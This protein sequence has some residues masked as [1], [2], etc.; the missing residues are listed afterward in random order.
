MLKLEKRPQSTNVSH[1][2]QPELESTHQLFVLVSSTEVDT[3]MLTRRVWE[4][5]NA[6]AFHVKFIG[7]CN[8]AGK[9]LATRRALVT[10][11]SMM[12]YGTLTSDIEVIV[13][14]NWIDSL[15]PRV[16][17]GDMVVYWDAEPAGLLRKPISQL[18]YA[19]LNVPL[20]IIP[21]GATPQ[22]ARSAWSSQIVAWIGFIA[23]VLGF[24]FLQTKIYQLAIGW[25]TVLALISVAVEFWLIWV[26]HNW[27][28]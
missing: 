22:D 26:W 6:G 13:G 25:A 21:G 12:N 20:Y 27:F 3:T 4:L 10:M 9:E 5:A 18:L 2:A 14:K 7:L 28:K 1:L 8:D 19:D 24:F 16:D 23:I 11:S 15:K 17:Q